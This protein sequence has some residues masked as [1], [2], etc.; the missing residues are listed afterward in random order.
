M[1][2]KMMDVQSGTLL[3]AG[4][5]TGS[6]KS[7]LAT[8]GGTVLGVGAG[9]VLGS[10]VGK[11]GGAIV[12][13]IA[14]GLA[15]NVAGAA[16]EQDLARLMR[17]V[18]AKTCKG[19]PARPGGPVSLTPVSA[20]VAATDA[21]TPPAAPAPTPP[22]SEPSA[23]PAGWE[24]AWPRSAKVGDVTLPT[25]AKTMPLDQLGTHFA[26]SEVVKAHIAPGAASAGPRILFTTTPTVLVLVDGEPVLKPLA[27]LNAE[28]VVN[29]RALLVKAAKKAKS[30]KTPKACAPCS[31]S[32][33]TW[34]GC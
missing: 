12:G 4:E 24:L 14:G 31:C 21:G 22:V 11:T 32:A 26:L 23:A 9:A 2:A 5:G 6:L 17:S 27:D 13:G 3:W 8:L 28:R 10:A 7:G 18:I 19:L 30:S 33:K 29:T 20:S 15:G 16:L 25:G 1:T 34:P